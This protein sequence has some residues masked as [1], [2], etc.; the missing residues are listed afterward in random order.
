MMRY[1]LPI[2]VLAVL[3]A[4]GGIAVVAFGLYNVSASSGHLPG[5]SWVLNTTFRNSVRLR[6]PEPESVPDLSIPGYAALGARHYDSACKMC[7]GAPGEP[8]SATVLSM[9]PQPPPLASAVS[10]WQPNE[11]FWIVRHGIK[12]SGMPAWP[13]ERDDDVWPVVAFL[14][15]AED[16]SVEGYRELAG[17]PQSPGISP[18]MSPGM[19][20]G[21]ADAADTGDPIAS[22]AASCVACH[23]SVDEAPVSPA[24]PRLDI[25]S[26]EYMASSLQAYREGRRFSGMMEQAASDLS[27]QQITA[28]ADHFT[29]PGGA[30]AARTLAAPP[31][32]IAAIVLGGTGETQTPACAACHGP[33]PQPLPAGNPPLAG[34]NRLYLADQM[35]AFKA[36]TRG[37]TDRAYLMHRMIDDLDS[38]TIEALAAYYAS[39]R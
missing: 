8:R 4:L 3:G 20:P 5:V 17:L 36:S 38:A 31:E 33:W 34:Q 37:G 22:L 27:D 25:L 16:L 14:A 39:A 6:A 11:L 15:Q 29:A 28:L 18:G 7:H 30:Q 2:G 13:A 10:H 9:V 35:K 32:D 12:M 26:A 19:A 1:L 23:G 24:A 21:T